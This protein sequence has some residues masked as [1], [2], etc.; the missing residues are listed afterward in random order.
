MCY[1]LKTFLGANANPIIFH[2]LS[3]RNGQTSP[4]H[5]YVATVTKE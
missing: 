4:R 2:I 1:Q 5:D 3:N